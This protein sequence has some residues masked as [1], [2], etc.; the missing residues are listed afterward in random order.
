MN[1]SDRPGSKPS[2]GFSIGADVLPIAA[3]L[4]GLVLLGT[5]INIHPKLVVDPVEKE[6]ERVRV[7]VERGQFDMILNT[8]GVL[9]IGVGVGRAL[10]LRRSK[11]GVS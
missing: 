7:L 4:L 2:S 9:L 3:V 11:G 8:G 1:P 10:W 6:R 5:T